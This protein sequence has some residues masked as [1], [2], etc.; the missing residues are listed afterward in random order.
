MRA[1]HQHVNTELPRGIYSAMEAAMDVVDTVKLTGKT[2][3]KA[4]V[5]VLHIIETRQ[6]S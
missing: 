2:K 3:V 4:K 5:K 1:R 6:V